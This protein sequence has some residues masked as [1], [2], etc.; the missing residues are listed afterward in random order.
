MLKGR[1]EERTETFS[2]EIGFGHPCR[3]VRQVNKFAGLE[4]EAA[5]S[6]AP[7]SLSGR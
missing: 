3:L 2:K 5:Y 4:R 6:P 7:A 1:D